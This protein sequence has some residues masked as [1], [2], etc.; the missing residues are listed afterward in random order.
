MNQSLEVLLNGMQFRRL[1]EKELESL[2]N[3]YDL[4]KIDMQILFYLHEAKERNT[5][6][7]IV[8]LNLFSKGHI[9]QSLGRMQGKNLVTMVH[10]EQDRRCLHILLCSDAEEIIEKVKNV[11]ERINADV[12]YGITEEEKRNFISVAKKINGNIQNTILKE[13]IK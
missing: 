1:L 12:F 5:P 9:S 6:R 10:D 4:C 7:D 8:E 11:Y 2:R 3:E 13:S